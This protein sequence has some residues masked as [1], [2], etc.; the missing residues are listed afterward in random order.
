M[1]NFPDIKE[2]LSKYIDSLN[3]DYHSS[4]SAPDLDQYLINI[5]PTLAGQNYTAINP[6]IK[7]EFSIVFNKLKKCNII[8]IIIVTCKNLLIYKKYIEDKD[9]ISD[10][11]LTK[12]AGNV[13]APF[14]DFSELN[15]KRIYNDDSLSANDKSFVL[16]FISKLYEVSYNVYETLS[17]PDVDVNEF[18]FIIL[19]SIDSVKKHIPRC[20]DAFDK[21]IESVDVLKSNFNDYYKDFIASSNPA[22]IMEHFVLDVAKNTK[23]TP[24]L[25]AQF[26]K[27]ITHYR[28]V[29]SKNS[30]MD[31]RLQTLFKTV[32][33]NFEELDKYKQDENTYKDSLPES[34]YTI[35]P[36]IETYINKEE[37]IKTE[38]EMQ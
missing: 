7:K 38:E 26:R 29:A 28:D 8:N 9:K 15:F 17:D 6:E 19:N 14:P 18:V 21:I 37:E 12:T 10:L 23:P 34:E 16:M 24:K 2:K 25:T 36:D 22:I 3:D 4:F 32:D 20:N 27:I 33:K 30:S 1:S 35:E 5:Q 11:F 13:I 31:P